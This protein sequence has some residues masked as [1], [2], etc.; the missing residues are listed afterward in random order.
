[1]SP[2]AAAESAPGVKSSEE[3]TGAA[4]LHAAKANTSSTPA[5][6]SA[7]EEVPER[8]SPTKLSLETG[9]GALVSCTGAGPSL[10]EAGTASRSNS[11]TASSS[12]S[13]PLLSTRVFG[14]DGTDTA[15]NGPWGVAMGVCVSADGKDWAMTIASGSWRTGATGNGMMLAV[16]STAATTGTAG[17]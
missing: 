11:G 6:G 1:M 15:A 5:S 7:A 12:L 13:P 16:G 2:A 4:L 10:S 14:T 8:P 9:G 3:A 17:T